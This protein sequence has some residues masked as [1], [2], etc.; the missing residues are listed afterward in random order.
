MSA[1]AGEVQ[2]HVAVLQE[3]LHG[4]AVGQPD[5]GQAH[6]GPGVRRVDQGVPV[7]DVVRL[8]GDERRNQR[9]CIPSRRRSS[10]T[11]AGCRTLAAAATCSRTFAPSGVSSLISGRQVACQMNM[12]SAAH[13]A[14]PTLRAPTFRRSVS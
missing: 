7:V 3:I 13:P 11:C 8:V 10:R 5:V 9:S 6:T 4:S 12:P 14:A 1:V 2:Q